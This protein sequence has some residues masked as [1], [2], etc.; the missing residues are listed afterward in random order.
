MIM[1]HSNT[2]QTEQPT[3]HKTYKFCPICMLS[4]PR[5]EYHALKQS[6]CKICF[7]CSTALAFKK[8][9]KCGSDHPKTAFLKSNNLEHEGF[10]PICKRCLGVVRRSHRNKTRPYDEDTEARNRSHYANYYRT[11]VGNG[12]IHQAD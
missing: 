5:K 10:Y 12:F 8:C 9:A 7:K 11:E 4:K 2:E 3:Q 1:E 6:C